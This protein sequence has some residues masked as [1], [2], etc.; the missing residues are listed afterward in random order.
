MKAAPAT[1]RAL[2]R[3]GARAPI[4]ALGLALLAACKSVGPD[5]ELPKDSLYSKQQDAPARFNA[6]AADGATPAQ[7]AASS[8]DALPADWWKLYADAR[9]DA[10]VE[11]A[12]DANSE[13]KVAAARLQQA[14]ARYRVA[15]NAGGFDAGVKAGAERAEIAAETLLMTEKLP[16]FNL[17]NVQGDVSYDLDLWGKVKRGTEAAQ[18][19]T[20]AVRVAVDLVRINVA[21]QTV[22]SYLEICHGNHE[23]EVAQHSLQIQRHSRDVA[24]RLQQAGRGTPTAVSRADA[25]VA[26]LQAAI[27]PLQTRTQAAGYELADLLGLAPDQV[28]SD[29]LQCHEAPRLA[30]PIPVGDGALL[31]KRRPDVRHAERELAASTAEIGVATAELYPS[32]RLGGMVG[33]N[34]LL[35]DF[36]KPA[37]QEWGIG[38]LISWEFPGKQA[39]ARVDVAKAGASVALA[40]FDKS[41][42]DALR[43]TQTALTRYADDLQRVAALQQARDH[44][45][46]AAADERTLYQAGRQP[47]LSSLDADRTLSNSEASLAD[48]QAQVSQDEVKLFLALGGGWQGAAPDAKH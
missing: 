18:A 37:T 13:L 19:N 39:H 24:A 38:P 14:Q 4:F 41:V 48:A 2:H 35:D 34:G 23:L 20:E 10:L 31:I 30:Q 42:L 17:A 32:I 27:P 29:A 22:A 16:V 45:Q 15:S 46:Q 25:Q 12:L 7:V 6:H 3:A 47:Y 8:Q 33:I 9:L 1:T 40:E 43:E 36:G 44:A 5:Y 21:A 26:L 28:P 11:Q